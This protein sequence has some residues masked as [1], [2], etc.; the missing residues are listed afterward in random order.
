MHLIKHKN[1]LGIKQDM[2]TKKELRKQILQKRDALSLQER[3]QKSHRII[4]TI[5]SSE[6]FQNSDTFL[7]FASYKSEVDVS[8]LIEFVLQRRKALYL[9]KVM[10]EEMEFYKITSVAQLLDGYCGIKEPKANPCQKFVAKKEEALF[11][12][13]PGAVFDKQG[14]R[15]GY[16]K[17]F[18]D[19]FLQKLEKEIPKSNLC[20][21]AVAFSCQIVDNGR[22]KREEHD[23]LP[24]YIVTETDIFN[25]TI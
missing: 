4:Q 2:E 25:C 10:G 7:L 16:G 18:Y 3:K 8:E 13:L 17:G 11:V 22:I 5:L 23:I 21:I 14:G 6:A 19:R 9:P 1:N 24:D 12:L 20:K 15:I